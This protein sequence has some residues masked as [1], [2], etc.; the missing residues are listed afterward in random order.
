[1]EE[2]AEGRREKIVQMWGDKLV[3]KKQNN[4][5]DGKDFG[6]FSVD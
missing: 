5:K 6:G 2:Q 1:M 4:D 3:H